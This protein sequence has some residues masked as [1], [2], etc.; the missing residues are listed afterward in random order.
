VLVRTSDVA[1]KLCLV[2]CFCFFFGL[3]CFFS[4]VAKRH[5]PAAGRITWQFN[6]RQGLARPYDIERQYLCLGGPTAWNKTHPT[7]VSFSE[8]LVHDYLSYVLRL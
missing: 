5:N 7:D 6:L 8:D 3:L 4:V 2:C 1:T